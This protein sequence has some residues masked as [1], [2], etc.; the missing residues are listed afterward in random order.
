MNAFL[1][2][3]I[4]LA[5]PPQISAGFQTTVTAPIPSM[6]DE[7]PALDFDPATP[8]EEIATVNMQERVDPAPVLMLNELNTVSL[9][10]N[11]REPELFDSSSEEA[12]YYPSYPSLKMTEVFGD[13]NCGTPFCSEC[14]SSKWRKGCG[15]CGKF[16]GIFKYRCL[17]STCDM[18][19]HYPYEPRGHSYYLYRPYN[20]Q[21]VLAHQTNP[22][23][24]ESFAPYTTTLFGPIYDQLLTEEEKQMKGAK[25]G[26]RKL[27]RTS[28]ELPDLE[29]ILKSKS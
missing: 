23:G 28:K 6:H 15:H 16:L 4:V 17:D 1:A 2:L 29:E 22:I 14:C 10:N 18:P 3:S 25:F 21:H 27:P 8:A 24:S 9:E 20:F 19:P 26:M 7:L 13:E 11:Y 12:A 5:A